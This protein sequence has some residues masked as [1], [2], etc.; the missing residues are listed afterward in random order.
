MLKDCWWIVEFNWFESCFCAW[1]PTIIFRYQYVRKHD[2][3]SRHRRRHCSQNWGDFFEI[4]LA[5]VYSFYNAVRYRRS[6]IYS[7][8]IKS[9]IAIS[10]KYFIAYIM[11]FIYIKYFLNTGRSKSADCFYVP[12]QLGCPVKRHMTATPRFDWLFREIGT[13]DWFSVLRQ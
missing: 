5:Y 13:P 7:W 12:A 8:I 1:L 2:Q 10:L 6:M 11:D 4:Y 9:N 3:Q